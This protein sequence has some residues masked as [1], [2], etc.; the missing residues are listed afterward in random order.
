MVPPRRSRESCHSNAS[1]KS[2]QACVTLTEWLSCSSLII[3]PQICVAI[4]G[5]CKY[6]AIFFENTNNYSYR[7]YDF[8]GNLPSFLLPAQAQFWVLP[9][10]IRQNTLC[11]LVSVCFH[12]LVTYAQRLQDLYSACLMFCMRTHT[13]PRFIVSSEGRESHQPQVFGRL[14][15]TRKFLSLTGLEPRTFRIGVGRA[16]TAPLALSN[17]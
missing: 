11:M 3:F 7:P 10:G 14:I 1:G 13:G 6:N 15:R 5:N 8:V 2:V 9:G 16:T 12:N 4:C 17:E